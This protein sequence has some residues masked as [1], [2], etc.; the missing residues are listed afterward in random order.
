[1]KKI[2][3]PVATFSRTIR[4]RP[5][6]VCHAGRLSVAFAHPCAKSPF[7]NFID[8][9]VAASSNAPR[10]MDAA[11]AMTCPAGSRM[12]VRGNRDLGGSQQLQGN[13]RSNP[14]YG[15]NQDV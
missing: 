14:V 4:A 13:R 1:M 11:V 9:A 12:R 6:H 3:H 7:V 2:G 8:A 15:G 5:V 10:R